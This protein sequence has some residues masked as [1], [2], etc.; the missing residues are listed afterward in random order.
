MGG[1]KG[2]IGDLGWCQKLK[3]PSPES[4][5]GCLPFFVWGGGVGVKETKRKAEIHG[6]GS[7]LWWSVQLGRV[8][9]WDTA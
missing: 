3:G 4:V 1:F 7:G 6:W 5:G 9:C 2:K 8:R